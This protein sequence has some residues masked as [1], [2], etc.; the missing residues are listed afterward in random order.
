MAYKEAKEA[1]RICPDLIRHILYLINECRN[2]Q[3][4]FERTCPKRDATC[5]EAYK[6][7]G[8]NVV[9]TVRGYTPGVC[10]GFVDRGT[11]P[12]KGT[13]EEQ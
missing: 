12:L 11:F 13:G 5:I 3:S 10:P 2:P 8:D 9:V 4:G 6:V 1:T 7:E